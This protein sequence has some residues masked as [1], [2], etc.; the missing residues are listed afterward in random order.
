MAWTCAEGKRWN[1]IS[2]YKK[3]NGAIECII[4]DNGIGRELSG[5]YKAQYETPHESK[6]ISLTSQ[7]L[8]WTNY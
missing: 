6:G 8:N 7:G 4:D 3:N 1:S 5:Q 2:F